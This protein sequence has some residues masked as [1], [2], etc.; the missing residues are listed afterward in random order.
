MEIND[1][2]NEEE[3]RKGKITG[4]TSKM[5]TGRA[6]EVPSHQ[7]PSPTPGLPLTRKLDQLLEQE[8]ER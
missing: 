3:K 1:V 7:L 2:R 5:D 4:W 8:W 6:Q